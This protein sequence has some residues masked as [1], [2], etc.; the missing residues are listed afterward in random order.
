MMERI[1]SVKRST[2]L[3]MVAVAGVLV[4]G[5]RKTA[6]AQS[7]RTAP[8]QTLLA[9]RPPMG[10][11]SWDSYGLR[12]NEEQFR[13]NVAVLAKK[14]KSFGYETAVID[15]GWFFRNPESRP[16][17]E[18]LQYEIDAN[19][20]Y[21][22]VPARF[23]SAMQHGENTGFAETARWVHSKGLKF[24][25]HIVRGIPRESVKRE[26]SIEGSHFTLQDAADQSD[27]CPW[28][29]T[30]WGVKDNEAGQ[31]WYDSL[32][33]QYASVGRG[34]PESRLHLR[35]SLQVE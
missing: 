8:S 2:L 21:L 13:D 7:S 30:N 15:E 24:G 3:C 27:P 5:S 35:P 29:P 11:N 6:P 22:P 32:L 28:D 4:V 26:L 34:L 1:F 20:R 16:H 31:A 25:I 33:R 12:I 10:W 23:P 19:G 9:P 14:L 17:P 18:L